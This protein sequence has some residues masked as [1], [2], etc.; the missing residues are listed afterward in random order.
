MEIARKKLNALVVG[1]GARFNGS[2]YRVAAARR[3]ARLAA[4]RACAESHLKAIAAL[5]DAFVTH[6]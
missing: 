2:H 6:S 1:P 4:P 5:R 3:R